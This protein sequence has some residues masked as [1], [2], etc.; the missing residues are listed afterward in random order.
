MTPPACLSTHSIA[1]F[2]LSVPAAEFK[3]TPVMSN[4]YFFIALQLQ[5]IGQPE[6]ISTAAAH[7]L[8]FLLVLT[9]ALAVHLAT[10]RVLLTTVR[11]LVK[12]SHTQ[13]DDKMVERRVFFRLSHLIPALVIH[14]LA[15]GALTDMPQAQ[16]AVRA[17]T[18]V[19]MILVGFMTGHALLD[20]ATDIFQ[21]VDKTKSFP[22]RGFVQAIK[23]VIFII[24]GIFV[25]SVLLDKS[26][27]VLIGSLGALTAVLMLV[28][29]DSI[30]GFVAGLH[31]SANR[32][33]AKGD[34]IELP[35]Y[36][37]DGEVIDIT[38]ATVKVLNWDRTVTSVP[39]YTLISNS[40]K[41]WQ[42]MFASGGRRMKRA[43][44]I[45]IETVRFCDPQML[46]KLQRIALISDYIRDKR[47]EIQHA[48]THSGIDA[49]PT[50]GTPAN[51]RQMTNIGSFRAYLEAYLRQNPLVHKDM[52]LLVRQL[53][54]TEHGL[55]VEIYAFCTDTRWAFYEGHMADIFDH[56]YGILP[57][58]GLR[59]FQRPSGHNL[60][61]AMQELHD[62]AN[63]ALDP[64]TKL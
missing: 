31:L 47:D 54:P 22:I 60:R 4:L 23:L 51:G 9:L 5:E 53:A 7:A 58:F 1:E 3:A 61:S 33:V 8:A 13:W 37:A 55:P 57:E 21:T 12:R 28:F 27:S 38:L 43:V 10:R 49:S 64:P 24:T 17:L 26:P 16:E 52:T 6:W 40:F 41:N 20:A 63:P 50:T 62:H 18:E 35:G 14:Y 59:P 11:R 29:K 34:W 39:T 30:L 48:N 46:D 2:C 15:P 45:D 36:N 25:M 56:I 42:S 19:Y 32:M 44:Y